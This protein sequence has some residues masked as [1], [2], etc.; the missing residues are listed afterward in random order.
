MAVIRST[1]GLPSIRTGYSPGGGSSL[2]ASPEA[3][4][5]AQSTSPAN[6]YGC[7]SIPGSFIHLSPLDQTTNDRRTHLL[8]IDILFLDLRHTEAELVMQSVEQPVI[9]LLVV[10][11]AVVETDDQILHPHLPD[12]IVLYET[13]GRNPA[14]GPVERNP[15]S[16]C[17]F[18]TGRAGISSLR[19]KSAA[20]AAPVY[21]ASRGDA[22]R[23]SARYFLPRQRPPPG[24]S[25]RAKPGVRYELRRTI[26]R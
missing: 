13:L 17:R 11:E 16:D 19:A 23:R 25:G 10:A 26:R 4:C 5:P 24:E 14:E 18:R 12:Q 21:R 7:D 20:A 2:R 1:P 9:S 15:R 22:G 6:R 8:G 3:I